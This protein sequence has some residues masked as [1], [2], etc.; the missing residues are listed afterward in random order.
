MP[1]LKARLFAD[2]STC[3]ITEDDAKKLQEL[4]ERYDDGRGSFSPTVYSYEEGFFVY[5]SDNYLSDYKN[6]SMSSAFINLLA[7]ANKQRMAYLNLD[8][9]G[10]IY[11][12]L[13]QFDW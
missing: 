3:H 11:D 1:K 6:A 7:M 5:V 2:I 13:P 9:D 10:E 12:E 4:A 8:I